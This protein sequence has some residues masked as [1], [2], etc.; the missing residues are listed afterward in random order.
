MTGLLG[1][2][3]GMTRIYDGDGVLRA[4]TVLQVGPCVVLQRKTADRDGYDAYQVGFETKKEK[5]ATRAERGHARKAGLEAAPRIV[6]EF[7]AVDEHEVGE[8]VTVSIF[9]GVPYVDVTGITKGK[10]FQGVVKRHGF[11]GGPAS[12]GSMSHRRPGSIG[13][14]QTPG[15]V[16]KGRKMPGR[17]GGRRRTVQNLRVLEVHGDRNLLVVAG[18]VP[19]PNGGWVEV[20]KA[21]KRPAAVTA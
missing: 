18:A 11:R 14:C 4:A 21:L 2:K 6:R 3:I 13:M 17:T 8:T 20:R 5:R 1:R 7:P 10:G 12:H 15:R 16:F 9:D 19:G